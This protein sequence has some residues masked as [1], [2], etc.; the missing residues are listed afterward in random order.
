MSST[1]Q[2]GSGIRWRTNRWTW[3]K[4]R[5][6]YLF[7]ES[8]R[9]GGVAFRAVDARGHENAFRDTIAA[10]SRTAATLGI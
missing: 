5:L 8:V 2:G 3:A 7:D 9:F 6:S 4:L 10:V 1:S